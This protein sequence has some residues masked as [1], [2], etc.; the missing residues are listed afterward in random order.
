MMG[1]RLNSLWMRRGLAALA[2]VVGCLALAAPAWAQ[3][4]TKAPHPL[5][6]K[7][8]GY[9]V[10][11]HREETFAAYEFRVGSG[12]TQSVEGRLIEVGYLRERGLPAQSGLAVV[13]NHEN[14][15]KAMG[16][17]TVALIGTPSNPN[18]LTFRVSKGGSVTWG[19]IDVTAGGN[20]FRIVT[21]TVDAMQQEVTGQSIGE[22]L[23][24]DGRVALYGIFFDT[25][26][27]T[28]RPDSDPALEAIRDL[29]TSQAA[30]SIFVVGHTD[31][32][33][34]YEANMTLSK[35]RAD[36]VVA[37]LATR[38]GI[39]AARLTAAGAG[40]LSPV[41]TNTTDEGRQLNRR[42]E[43]VAR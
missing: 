32:T 20:D 9:R 15:I 30:L 14:A 38:Y 13:R 5:F 39:P 36:A 21:I 17:Q 33:G 7:M 23:G 3:E 2:L 37:A 24:R 8:D 22:G 4:E 1:S 40:P 25:G 43:I 11:S 6:S 12:K 18:Y 41:A 35:Q 29:L 26:K 16:G 28:L 19:E 42:V 27:A 34:A 10:E 31:N